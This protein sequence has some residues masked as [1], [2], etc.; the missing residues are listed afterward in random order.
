MEVTCVHI[1]GEYFIKC[2]SLETILTISFNLL[3][4]TGTL[5]IFSEVT[6]VDYTL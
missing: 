5:V 3:E 2:I 1:L 6:L 4:S